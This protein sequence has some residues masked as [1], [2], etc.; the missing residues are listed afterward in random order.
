MIIQVLIAVYI[1]YFQFFAIH[2]HL[3]HKYRNYAEFTNT[4]QHASTQF[5]GVLGPKDQVSD[6]DPPVW[7]QYLQSGSQGR[8][9]TPYVFIRHVPR[10]DS[11]SHRGES[12]P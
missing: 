9:A 1:F 10:R 6:P 8:R 4:D 2:S 7:H 5:M 11:Q 12:T 3:R